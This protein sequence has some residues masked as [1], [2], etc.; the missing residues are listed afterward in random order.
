MNTTK[1]HFV[2][3][4]DPCGKLIIEAAGSGWTGERDLPEPQYNEYMRGMCE[5]VCNGV[6]LLRSDEDEVEWEILMGRSHRLIFAAA[7]GK[8]D[9]LDPEVALSDFA[10]EYPSRFEDDYV[11]G[12]EA[13]REAFAFDALAFANAPAAH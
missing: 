9:K 11:L 4:F 6:R 13:A 5:L 8:L 1:I 10:D 2:R 12:D 3:A 7:Q